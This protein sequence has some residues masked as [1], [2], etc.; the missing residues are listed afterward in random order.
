V[1]F[2]S[3]NHTNSSTVPLTWKTIHTKKRCMWT[4]RQCINTRVCCVQST[5]K[6]H[7]SKARASTKQL[8]KKQHDQRVGKVYDMFRV[9][10]RCLLVSA[11]ACLRPSDR[12]PKAKESKGFKT[13]RRRIRLALLLLH[14]HA[15]TAAARSTSATTASWS[16]QTA[17]DLPCL[18]SHRL[19]YRPSCAL[20][21]VCHP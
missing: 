3:F 18:R 20:C 8:S 11:S 10:M 15:P 14:A 19:L 1:C 17:V 7:V 16:H 9:M 5:S 6:A 2:G 13:T 12:N 21:G 4:R